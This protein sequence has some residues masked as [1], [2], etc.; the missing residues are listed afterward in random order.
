MQPH[1]GVER[2]RKQI[3]INNFIGGITWAIGVFVGSTIVVAILVFV[4]SKVNLIPVVGNFVTQVTKNVLQ[5]NSQL[6]K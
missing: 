4:F 3:M 6:L 2:S 5:N 1:E